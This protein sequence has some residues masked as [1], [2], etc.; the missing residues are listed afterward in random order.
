MTVVKGLSPG[1]QT[2]K[3][4]CWLCTSSA[5]G[6]SVWDSDSPDDR[7]RG[8]GIGSWWQSCLLSIHAARS[9]VTAVLSR[10]ELS[11]ARAG[12]LP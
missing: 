1:G 6:V 12:A 7:T 8:I 4:Q 10:V 2:G 11:R 3:A 9:V 5:A